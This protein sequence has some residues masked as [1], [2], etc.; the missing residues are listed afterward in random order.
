MKY[1]VLISILL[2]RLN[3][4]QLSLST[5]QNNIPQLFNPAAWNTDILSYSF[6]PNNQ[7]SIYYRSQ[8]I[9]LNLGPKY[10]GGHYDHFSNNK[11]IF[12]AGINQESFGPLTSTNVSG[13]YA[14]KIKLNNWSFLSGGLGMGFNYNG[15]NPS[16]ITIRDPDD[17][18]AENSENS[19]GMVFT[20]GAF[21]SSSGKTDITYVFG[22]SY[23]NLVSLLFS[24][25]NNI[26][27]LKAITI[28]GS[29]TKFLSP[30]Y[31]KLSYYNLSFV[32]RQNLNISDDTDV[33]FKYQWN[34]LISL[35]SGF[36]F[37][38]FNK[39]AAHAIHF[40]V[41]IPMT[42]ILKLGNRAL[43]INYSCDV[44]LGNPVNGVGLSHEISFGFLF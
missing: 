35:Q 22:A 26:K 7:F 30:G 41:G 40:D 19:I 5:F 8:F 17:P 18:L 38:T 34:G 43:G 3:G 11:V 36:R 6:L 16:K 10:F 1:L 33:S 2:I 24:K 4:Q 13:R 25:T 39:L 32:Y 37:G 12:G 42:K 44:P 27:A 29:I 9:G 20:P 15:Y 14:Y 31:K 28:H 23:N 21:I